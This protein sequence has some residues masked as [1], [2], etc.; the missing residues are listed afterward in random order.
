MRQ[1]MEMCIGIVDMVVF[2]AYGRYLPRYQV[3]ILAVCIRGS[4]G[5]DQ[6]VLYKNIK[7]LNK[8]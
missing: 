7:A 4:N 2:V 8:F 6:I 5:C 1:E 3:R